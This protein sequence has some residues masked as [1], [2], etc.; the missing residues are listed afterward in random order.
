MEKTTLYSKD[1]RGKIR[2]WSV[3]T[4][5]AEI[6]MESGILNGT[7]KVERRA[8]KP[9]NVGQSN[10]TTAEQQAEL[11]AASRISKQRDKGYFDTMEA[12][13]GTTVV[14][15]M[16]AHPFEKREKYVKYPCY[17]QPKLDGTRCLA[18]V[19][20][21]KIEL[22]TRKGKPYPHL[23]HIVEALR[24]LADL[25]SDVVLDG[26]VYCHG[27][28]PFERLAGL[29]RKE[30]LTDEDRADMLKI[31]Y[32]CYDMIILSQ[33]DAPFDLR[34][35]RLTNTVDHLTGLS[36]G[37]AGCVGL[38]ETCQAFSKDDVL[39]AHVRYVE[40]GYEG[41]MVRNASGPYALNNR[42]NDLL[43]LKSFEDDE[44]EIVGFREAEGKD[45]GTVIWRCKTKSGDEFDVRPRGS[46]E[47]R[48]EWFRNGESYIG[49]LLTVRFQELSEAGIP[50]F[51]VGISPRDYD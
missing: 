23:E 13:E 24:P 46:F 40:Q 48:A 28:L 30:T 36:G 17:V 37:V 50:R 18:I 19:K 15:P 42:S 4:E 2:V 32:R 9:K 33:P 41:V 35:A 1:S 7:L 43:K 14:L 49:K 31:G 21:G 10:E 3:W 12:A 47:Q 26:E 27:E 11:E 20:D 16:L 8:A 38:V 25:G 34:S 44:F 6:L 45:E 22:I 5:G 51:P 29:V 39:A